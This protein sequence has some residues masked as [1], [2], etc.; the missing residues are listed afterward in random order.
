MSGISVQG[1]HV[2]A[3]R[4]QLRLQE[5]YFV[6]YFVCDHQGHQ[7]FSQS[8]ASVLKHVLYNCLS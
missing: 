1:E 4:E 3:G 5:G 7:T 8:V 2:E 6:Q